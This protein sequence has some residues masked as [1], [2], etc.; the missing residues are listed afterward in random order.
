MFKEFKEFIMRGNVIDMA[1]GI[2][3][4]VAFG[5]IV[6]SLV[7][8]VIMPPIGVVLGDVDFSN[9]FVVLKHGTTP[10]PYLSPAQAQAAGAVSLNY[11]IFLNTIISFFIIAL[12]VFILIHQLDRLKKKE[13]VAA[14]APS[15]KECVYC[16]S[17]IPI[18]A[19]RCPNCTSD[20]RP[21]AR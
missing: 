19:I 4:G 9:L 8:D 18:K 15:T 12:A 13:P 16:F 17:T 11:G 14:P 5:A 1:V 20:L 3:I 2:I 21:A 10:G 6:Q 7:K